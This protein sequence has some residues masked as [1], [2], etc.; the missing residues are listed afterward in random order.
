MKSSQFCYWLQ[1]YFE[2]A[3]AGDQSVSL[4]PDQ[5]DVVQRHLSMVFHHELDPEHGDDAEQK[6]LQALH[7]GLNE[8]LGKKDP[9]GKVYRC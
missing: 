6:S 7:D 1:G 8:Q 5:I 3:R 4:N 9:D 2:I